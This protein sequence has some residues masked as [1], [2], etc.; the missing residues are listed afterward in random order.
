MSGV[1]AASA[2]FNA[3][4]LARSTSVRKSLVALSIRFC[5]RVRS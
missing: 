2:F 1:E 4:S 3:A 5:G